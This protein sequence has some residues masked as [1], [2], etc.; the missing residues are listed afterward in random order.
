MAHHPIPSLY[1]YRICFPPIFVARPFTHIAHF[2]CQK[3]D[4]RASERTWLLS[5]L[6]SL[7][8]KIVRSRRTFSSLFFLTIYECTYT[9]NDSFTRCKPAT[10]HFLSMPAFAF[11][12]ALKNSLQFTH[13]F[14]ILKRRR[15]NKTSTSNQSSTLHS[16]SEWEVLREP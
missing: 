5:H 6:I 7:P 9:I 1:G 13:P 15:N 2:D 3:R 11:V 8:T 16:Q 10:T 12:Q 14:P 4:D